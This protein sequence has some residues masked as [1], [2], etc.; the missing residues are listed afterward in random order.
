MYYDR[1]CNLSLLK[2]KTVAII[3]YGD[4]YKRQVEVFDPRYKQYSY[5]WDTDTGGTLL[6]DGIVYRLSLIHI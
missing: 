1:D 6:E 4:V 2:G 5:F 3:G